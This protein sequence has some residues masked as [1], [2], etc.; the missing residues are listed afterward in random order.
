MPQHCDSMHMT[1]LQCFVLYFT[2]SQKSFSLFTQYTSHY[3][4]KF[5]WG[6][7][8][9]RQYFYSSTVKAIQWAET[10]LQCLILVTF[11]SWCVIHNQMLTTKWCLS[12][13]SV[14]QLWFFKHIMF[15]FKNKW[16]TWHCWPQTLKKKRLM[17]RHSPVSC[18]VTLKK[19][20]YW[21][22]TASSFTLTK[23]W[24]HILF[25]AFL[26]FYV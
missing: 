22:W 21:K 4:G 24:S 6:P 3:F 25:E 5:Y 23:I 20:R 14:C 16:F 18:P 2:K 15:N 1:P 10:S 7:Y 11:W 26:V 13:I 19:S 12:K 17:L 9:L 8:H